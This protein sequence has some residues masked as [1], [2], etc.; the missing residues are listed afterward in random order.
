MNCKLGGALWSIKIPL[1]NTMI[2][3]ID[4]F[5]DSNK[6]ANSVSAFVASIDSKFTHWYSQAGVQ[7]KK[8]EFVNSLVI[9][10]NNALKAYERRNGILPE[11]IIIFR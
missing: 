2:I 6:Q 4:S 9:A 8:E 3:G 10:L 7:A 1:Q 11:R 5:H